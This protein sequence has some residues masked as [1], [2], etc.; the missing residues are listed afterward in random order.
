MCLCVCVCVCVNVP[1]FD[2]HF[3]L[4]RLIPSG[5]P[6][7]LSGGDAGAHRTPEP[8]TPEALRGLLR[9]LLPFAP[10]R[11]WLRSPPH[12]GAPPPEALRGS[13]P[14]PVAL[15]PPPEVAPEPTA[16]RSP[17]SEGSPEVTPEPSD[18]GVPPV[19]PSGGS[20]EVTPEPSDP[21]VPPVRGPGW[22]RA[23]RSTPEPL[24]PPVRGQLRDRARSGLRGFVVCQGGS[25][26]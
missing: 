4:R 1:L 13:T 15:R 16:L 19:R 14:E 26:R 8:P 12:S 9:S 2:S 24:R 5:S 20:P 3:L 22:P 21:G 7:S 17:P 11:R 10:P 25:L 23:P 6:P 18:P